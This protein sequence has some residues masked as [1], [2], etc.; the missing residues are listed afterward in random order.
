VAK[1]NWAQFSFLHIYHH[2]SIFMTYWLVVT[3]AYDG[4]TY[5]PIVANSL[6]HLVMYGYYLGTA[7]GLNLSA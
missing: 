3:T 6:V 4:D 1:G 5:Y 2:M 7:L